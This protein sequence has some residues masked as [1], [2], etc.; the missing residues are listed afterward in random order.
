M[1][2]TASDGCDDKSKFDGFRLTL[3]V[4]T[5]SDAHGVFDALAAGGRIDMP[6]CKKFWLPCYGML[7]DKF[8]FGWMVVVP[9]PRQ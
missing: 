5:E 3:T 1:K 8:N 6:L 7:T 9:G 4:H 2:V